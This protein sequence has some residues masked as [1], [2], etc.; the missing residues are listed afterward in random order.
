VRVTAADV[1]ALDALRNRRG[2]VYRLNPHRLDLEE[3]RPTARVLGSTTPE[4]L[5][6]TPA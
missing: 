1:K 4:A 2:A 6:F 5:Y 3:P